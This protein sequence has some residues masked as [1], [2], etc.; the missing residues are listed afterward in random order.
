M[1]QVDG[2]LYRGPFTDPAVLKAAGVS[3]VICLQT[4]GDRVFQ[5]VYSEDVLE[6]QYGI[7]LKHYPLSDV[8]FPKPEQFQL[9]RTFIAVLT[10]HGKL[11][12]HCTAGVDRT[13]V[14]IADHRVLVQGWS[15]NAAILEMENLG[16]HKYIY[17]WW[18][19]RLRSKWKSECGRI[20]AEAKL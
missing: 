17:F 12:V 20:G 8:F 11:F 2:N 19:D 13:G 5:G 4:P 3:Y 18:E 15:P 10:P 7:T 1:I 9:L 6:G 14:V 16:F